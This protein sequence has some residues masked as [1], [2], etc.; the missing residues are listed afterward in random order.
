[1][2][3]ES[4]IPAGHEGWHVEDHKV[5]CAC[6]DDCGPGDDPGGALVSGASTTARMSM[7]AAA[8]AWESHVFAAMR[9]Q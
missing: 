2:I 4:M 3:P 7:R 9:Q 8:E 5:V 1:M 6:G